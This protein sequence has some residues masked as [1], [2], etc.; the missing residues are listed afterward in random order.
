MWAD[1]S[2]R[3]E[4][5]IN[6]RKPA[7]Q[8][9]SFDNLV[10]DDLT[11]GSTADLM[12]G[13]LAEHRRFENLDLA[14]ARI[15]GAEFLECELIGCGAHEATL[16]GS[17]FV[18]TR[19]ARL[20]APVLNLRGTSFRNVEIDASRIGAVEWYDTQMHRVKISNSKLG[21]MNLRA[22]SLQD[23]EFRGCTIDELDL[24]GAKLS[25]IRFVDTTVDRLI[26]DG[27]RSAHVDL[28][29]ASLRAIEGFDGLRGMT[30]SGFQA[31]LMA[32]LF[33]DHLGINVAD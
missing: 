21:W 4:A 17:R 28:R 15:T 6:R 22:S 18:E 26:L 33:A 20:D 10:L 5:T 8:A 31:S 24:S 27:A 13:G 32:E 11:E 30:L 9:P 1:R 7:L 3:Q 16:Q 19:F 12:P 25:R 23:V 2:V 29:G 14:G